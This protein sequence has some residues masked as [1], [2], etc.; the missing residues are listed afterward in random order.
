MGFR[1]NDGGDD[2]GSRGGSGSSENG[3]VWSGFIVE[4][5]GSVDS[6]PAS[7][8]VHIVGCLF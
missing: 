1:D 8:V 5:D 4:G 7:V 2:G 3:G 6:V